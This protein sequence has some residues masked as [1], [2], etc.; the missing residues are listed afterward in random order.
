MPCNCGNKNKAKLTNTG[1]IQP[2]SIQPSR[3]FQPGSFQPG[4]FQ[5]GSIQPTRSIQPSRSIQPRSIQTRSIQ[6]RS[7]QPKKVQI[8]ANQKFGKPHLNATNQP[9]TIVKS[10]ITPRANPKLKNKIKKKDLA[11][12]DKIHKMAAKV[13]SLQD[14]I[15]F[16]KYIKFLSKNFPCPKCRPHIKKRLVKK[17]I[18]KAYRKHK[19]FGVVRWSWKF[20]NKTNKRLGKSKMPWDEFKRIYLD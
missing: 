11:S 2:R 4:S 17:P 20:H 14:A 3:S 9:R 12:W 7:I 10:G 15:E 8:V 16:E 19:K 6:P 1:S 13:K 18:L 5:P